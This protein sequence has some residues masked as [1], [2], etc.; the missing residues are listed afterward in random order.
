V[1]W[2]TGCQPV[3]ADA[4]AATCRV[5]R[6]PG[7][8]ARCRAAEDRPIGSPPQA[9]FRATAFAGEERLRFL[10][11]A[12]PKLTLAGVD[13]RCRPR[14]APSIWRAI[15]PWGSRSKTVHAD[16]ERS[17]LLSRRVGRGATGCHSVTRVATLSTGAAP[18]GPALAITLRAGVGRPTPSRHASRPWI[19]HP[20]VFDERIDHVSFLA[21]IEQIPSAAT[22]RAA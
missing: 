19:R 17:P 5:S 8:T 3:K 12:Q 1:S 16:E 9:R 18:A 13:T 7:W 15:D 4:V 20:A 2:T 21:Y 6:G 22:T 14:R 11:D 10:I